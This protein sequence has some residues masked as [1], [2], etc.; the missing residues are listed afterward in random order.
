L[1]S[2]VINEQIFCGTD[3]KHR[4]RRNRFARSLEIF[5]RTFCRFVIFEI[6]LHAYIEYFLDTVV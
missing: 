4:Y 6:L 5:S 1:R 3:N 2:T